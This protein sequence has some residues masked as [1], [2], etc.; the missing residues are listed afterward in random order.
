MPSGARREN[1]L[2]RLTIR[3][4]LIVFGREGWRCGFGQSIGR[5]VFGRP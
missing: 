3:E 2:Q 4:H 1:I 5:E